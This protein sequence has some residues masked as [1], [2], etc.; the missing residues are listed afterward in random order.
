MRLKL[1]VSFLLAANLVAQPTQSDRYRYA[2]LVSTAKL[3]NMIRYLHPRVTGD[4]TQWD[5][6]LMAAIPKIE[7]AH[8]DDELAV[9]LDAMLATLND[10]CTRIA[11]G[12][13]GK[14]VTVQSRE[15]DTMVIRADNGD[16]AGSL[17]AG[18]MI[19]MGIPQTSHIVWDLRGSRMPACSA[20]RRFT[21]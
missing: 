19:K 14:G 13:P 1:A 20:I 8:S 16:L 9:A 10:P 17:G 11:H 7:A 12:M 4:S 2:P 21:R 5:A 3:W 6:A 18:L 15:S